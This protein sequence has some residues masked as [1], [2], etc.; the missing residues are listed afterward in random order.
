[1]PHPTETAPRDGNGVT[2]KMAVL[3]TD[4]VQGQHLVAIA[5]NSVDGGIK[6][7]TTATISFTM[8][9]VDPRDENFA[10]VWCFQGLDGLIYPAV[11]TAAGH[12]LVD[13][14]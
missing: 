10:T 14:T 2:A 8:Q 13:E 1:M 11:A 6:Y 3:N 5:L 4:T 12:L 9:P 7:D